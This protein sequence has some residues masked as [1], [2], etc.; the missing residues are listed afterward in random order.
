MRVLRLT[1][2]LAFAVSA[3]SPAWAGEDGP[4]DAA[5][6]QRFLTSDYTVCDA[7]F[8]ARAFE[9]SVGD[10]KAYIGQKIAWGTTDILDQDLDRA[11]R[12]AQS[13]PAWRCR[14]HQSG[15]SFDDAQALAAYWSQTV[16]EA[17][18]TVE[19]KIAH[20]NESYLRKQV[21]P[22]ARAA[23]S[24]GHGTHSTADNGDA[25]SLRAFF[26][27]S[28]DTC[29]AYMV[30]AAF[31][32]GDLSQSKVAVGYKVLHGWTDQVDGAL[33]RAREAHQ[34]A[35]TQPCPFH[36][37]P[38]TFA[39][40]QALAKVWGEDVSEAKSRIELKYAYGTESVIR[41]TLKQA[42]GE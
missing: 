12:K 13:D 7:H 40:A 36:L 17:K 35:G 37:T 28:Y 25:A 31:G 29:H 2:V 14:F 5:M 30:K 42:R 27:S 16:S 21:L 33:S 20:N 24:G 39:D 23:H 10:S 18:A 19:Q 22:A 34:Q 38:Y 15:L 11:K 3:A 41:S 26:D 1:L 32:A 6:I 4:E 8:I 9:F